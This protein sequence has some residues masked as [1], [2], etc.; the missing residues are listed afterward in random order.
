MGWDYGDMMREAAD[1]RAKE[2]QD[3]RHRELIE[4]Y[5][6]DAPEEWALEI[7][8][9]RQALENLTR[10]RNAFEDIKDALR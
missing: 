9:G 10:A 4:R 5:A 2:Q 6:P 7:A 8:I 3:R 1:R